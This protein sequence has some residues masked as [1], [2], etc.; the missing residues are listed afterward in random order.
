MPILTR[1]VAGGLVAT[2]G[3]AFGM[4]WSV[5]YFQAFHGMS[6]PAASVTSSFYFWGCLPGMLGSAWLCARFGRP[7][8]LLAAG[9]VGTAVAM[10]LILFVLHGQP[11]LSAA[12]FLLGL[13]NS[14]YALAF[15]M[16]KDEAPTEL[17]G[18]AMGLTNMLIMGVG[19]LIFQPLI[20]L[21]AHLRGQPVPD[22]AALSVTI[23]APLLALAVLAALA[24]SEARR[25][26]AGD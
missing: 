26:P 4:L 24:L 19:G 7:A 17:S 15:T 16:V 5:S 13:S 1:A 3:V 20:G 22:A 12:M 10:G 23:A 6:L 9:A 21:L 18:V 14:F 8:L 11:A 25:I 2:T